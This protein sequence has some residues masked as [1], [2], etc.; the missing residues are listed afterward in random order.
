MK[1]PFI[2]EMALGTLPLAKFKYYLTQ[3]SVY[4]DDLLSSLLI[5]ASRSRDRDL[6]DFL[7]DLVKATI[8]GEIAMQK[9]LKA[10]LK[11]M[12]PTRGYS[13]T[14]LAYTSYM[15]RV[16]AFCSPRELLAALA[17]CF[18]SYAELGVMLKDTRGAKHEIYG[19]W[20]S[21]YASDEYQRL[22]KRYLEVLDKEAE[23][24][25]KVELSRMYSHFKVATWYEKK[26]W[27][28]AYI[29]EPILLEV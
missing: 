16:S 3:D 28:M 23:K 6:R 8:E 11:D 10:V 21:G 12:P 13:S 17:P 9:E 26:F 20:I 24:A 2:T 15:L 22:I 5:S 14:T 29:R 1:H 27:D 19:I 4:L 18:W 7:V 25:E